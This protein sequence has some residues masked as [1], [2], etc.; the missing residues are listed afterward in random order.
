MGRDSTQRPCPS[1]YPNHRV[2]GDTKVLSVV[3]LELV[4]VGFLEP[5]API[6]IVDEK[7]EYDGTCDAADAFGAFGPLR[8]TIG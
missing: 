4:V 6:F 8:N 7:T 5:C 1:R 3:T 2:E